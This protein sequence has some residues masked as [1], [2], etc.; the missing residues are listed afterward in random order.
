MFTRVLRRAR[1]RRHR[2]LAGVVVLGLAA[3]P[4]FLLPSVASATLSGGSPFNA[5]DGTPDGNTGSAHPD[6]P[7]GTSDNSYSGSGGGAKEDDVCPA[8]ETGSIPNHKADL[9]NLHVA[10]GKGTSHT[11]L[12]LAWERAIDSGTVTLD[13]ELNESGELMTGGAC[14]SGNG[15]NRVRT[16]GEDRL[17]TYDMQASQDANT[18]SI[19]VRTWQST[20]WSDATALNSTIAEGSIGQDLLF[21][22]M[23]IDLEAAGI[24]TPGVCA[25]FA[26]VFL[27]SRSSN[28]M[29]SEMKDFVLPV[30]E[31][32]SNCGSLTVSKTTNGGTGTFTFDVECDDGLR[33]VVIIE[34]S[35]SASIAD[36]PIGTTCTVTETDNPLFNS[37]VIPGDGTVTIGADGSTVAFVNTAKANGLTLDK[38][39]NGAD[40]ATSADALSVHAG[41]PLTYAV[42]VSNTGQVPLTITAL[43]DPLYPDIVAACPQSVDSVLAPGASFTCTYRVAAPGDEHNVAA[44]TAVDGLGRS[45]TVS[46][47]TYVDVINPAISIVKTASPE[48][49]GGSGNVTYTYVVTNTG[50]TPLFNIVVDDDVLGLI[51]TLGELAAGESV[52][53]H[54]TVAVDVTTPPKN[55]GTAVGTDELGKTVS[56]TDD[57]VITLV[58]PAVLELPRTGSPLQSQTQAALYLIEVGILLTLVGRR[59]RIIRRAG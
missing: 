23:A 51:G 28:S 8:V 35:G 42:V 39:V 6:L 30:A 17:I 45:L 1:Y 14:G 44:V 38:K 15:V 59:R 3:A 33:Q 25:N 4:L 41:D 20:G 18:I 58:L 40:H 52:T 29:Q 22:E 31:R 37:T 19:S 7:T 10:T 34:D 5:L 32:V 12:Y 53:I 47:G 27:K 2:T 56:A 36:I 24:F 26:S 43:S 48:S 54:K 11:F 46:D 50:D 49:V 16:P 57:A 21:G 13:F 55:I 9:T